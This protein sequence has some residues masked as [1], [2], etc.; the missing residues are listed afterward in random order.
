LL[1]LKFHFFFQDFLF[2]PSS[3]EQAA[4]DEQTP[5]PEV[6]AAEDEQTPVPEV[7]AAV[8]EQATDPKVQAA[9]EVVI[10][11]EPL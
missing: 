10:N 2:D 9:E 7:Q 1:L 6:Q 8:D 3:D 11:C 4:E 5:V